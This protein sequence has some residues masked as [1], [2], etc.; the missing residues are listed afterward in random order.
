MNFGSWLLWGFVATMAQS[1]LLAGSQGLGLTRLNLP[2]I[3]GMMVTADRDRARLY[4]F[5]VHVLNGWLFSL[6]YVLIFE[7]LQRTSWWLGA[8]IGLGQALFVLVIVVSLMP[9]LHP[10][11]ASEQHGPSANRMLEPPGFLA[12]NYGIRTPLS[13]LIAHIVFGIILGVFYHLR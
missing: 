13:V 3:M 8:L 7:S 11:M 12:L 1:I 6:L 10:R 4:G 2:Y 5:L 9:G